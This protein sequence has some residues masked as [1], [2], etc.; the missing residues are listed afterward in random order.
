MLSSEAI[1]YYSMHPVEF[2]QDVI[3]ANPDENQSAILR[4][5]V[6]NQPDRR[7]KQQVQRRYKQQRIESY[8][9]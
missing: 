4:S 3:K 6:H 9:G 7:T 8:S 2:V 5:L 1:N